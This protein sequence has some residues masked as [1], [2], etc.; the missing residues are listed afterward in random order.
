MAENLRDEH[1]SDAG[2][3][4]NFMNTK[5]MAL[6]SMI[7]L[8]MSSSVFAADQGH[9]KVTFTG[10]IIDSPCSIKPESV[11]QTVSLGQISKAS[12]DN[13]GKSTPRNFRIDLENCSFGTADAKN[14]VTVTFTGAE[15]T[16][17]KGSLGISGT[18]KGASVVIAD[19]SGQ[20]ITLAQPTNPQALQNGSNS[21]NFS[22]FLQ[23]DG[24]ADSITEGDFQAVTDFTLAY[25]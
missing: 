2:L 21:I 13:S 18:A 25:N 11:D 7:V 5:K 16:V 8:G 19:G 22:A 20:N 1:S 6:A 15:S 24:S 23:G 9:G 4:G 3:K 10:S 12:L 14:K 17:N